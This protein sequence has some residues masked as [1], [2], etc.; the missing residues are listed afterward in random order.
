MEHITTLHKDNYQQSD[1]RYLRSFEMDLLIKGYRIESDFEICDS[2]Y[3][4]KVSVYDGESLY[5]EIIHNHYTKD[6]VV[7]YYQNGVRIKS[8]SYWC[9]GEPK[10]KSTQYYDSDGKEYIGY[11]WVRPTVSDVKK[12][13]KGQSIRNRI[14]IDESELPIYISKKIIEL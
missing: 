10:S 14:E 13:Y 5:C 9:D 8:E 1:L 2:E 4:E 3:T 7:T 12:L 11:Q 6:F